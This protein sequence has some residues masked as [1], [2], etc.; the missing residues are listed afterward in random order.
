MQIY[1][2]LDFLFLESI[3]KT[4]PEI[5]SITSVSLTALS[6]QIILVRRRDFGSYQRRDVFSMIKEKGYMKKHFSFSSFFEHHY[7]MM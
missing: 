2:P 5:F 6:D 1:S 4:E 3:H 7:A